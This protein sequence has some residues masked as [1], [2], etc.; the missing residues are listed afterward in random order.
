MRIT[1]DRRRRLL[2]FIWLLVLALATG[3]LLPPQPGT[4]KAEPGTEPPVVQS[5]ASDTLYRFMDLVNDPNNPDWRLDATLPSPMRMDSAIFQL[6]RGAPTD[7]PNGEMIRVKFRVPE[8]GYYE[9]RLKDSMKN[10]AG[11]Y[12]DIRIDGE[13]AASGYSFYAPARVNGTESIVVKRMRLEAGEHTLEFAGVKSVLLDSVGTYY[14][15]LYL[16]S[17]R[18]IPLPAEEGGPATVYPFNDLHTGLNR[19]DWRVEETNPTP[20]TMGTG[21][22]QMIRGAPTADPNGAF[23]RLSFYVPETGP[24]DIRMSSFKNYAGGYADIRI[25]SQPIAEDFSFYAPE[26]VNNVETVLAE[27]LHLSKGPHTLEFAGTQSVLLPSVNSYYLYLYLNRLEL[28]PAWLHNVRLTIDSDSIMESQYVRAGVTAGVDLSNA[29]V[30]YESDNMQVLSPVSP[31][32]LFEAVGQGSATLTATV[33]LDGV[34]ASDSRTFTVGPLHLTS[35]K[36]RSTIYTAQKTANARANALEYDWAK[37]MRD[38]AVAK[39]QPYVDKGWEYLWNSI[40]PQTIPRSY[41]VNQPLGSP[42][43]GRAIDAYGNYPY[44]GDP[45]STP[46]KIVDPSS[47]YVFPTNDFGAYYNSGLDEQGVFRPELADRDLLV[48]EL[49]PER[50]PNWGVDDGYGWVDE[51]GNR[52]TF[53]AYYAHWY[54]WYAGKAIVFN[55]LTALRDAYLYTGDAQ[56]AKAGLV[57]L[58][59]I[60][61]LYPDLDLRQQDRSVFWNSDGHLGTGK[62]VG[63]IWETD[64]SKVLLSAYDAFYPATQDAA[65]MQDVLAFLAAKGQQ[66]KLS[67]K[68]SAVGMRKNIEDGIVRQVYPAVQQANIYGNNGFHQSAL[69]MAAVVLDSLPE[70]RQWL[71]FNFQSGELLRDPIR[72]TGGNI[73]ASL[74]NT[75]DRDGFGN[76]GS[77]TYN[78]GWLQT[79]LVVADLLRGYDLYPEADLYANVKFG[80]MFSSV[81]DLMMLNRY[82]PS[83]GDS[84]YTGN[85]RLTMNKDQLLRAFEVYGDPV[86]AQLVYFLN[87]NRLSAVHGDIFS[88]NPGAIGEDIEQIIDTYGT[89]Q[90]E[91]SHLSGFGFAA[92]RDGISRQSQTGGGIHML[93]P[94]LDVV[95]SSAVYRLFEAS[96]TIQLEAN[97]PNHSITFAFP[98]ETAGTYRVDLRPFRASTYGIYDVYIDNAY[99]KTIDFFGS[100][101]ELEPL[102][103]LALT[104]GEHTLSFRNAGKSPQSSNYKMGVT[105]L[106]L[107]DV[108]NAPEPDDQTALDTLRGLWMYYGTSRIHGHRDTLNLGIHAYG[109]DLAPD[110]GY[111]KFADA[112]DPHR[113]QW[114]NNTISHNTVVVDQA[115]QN[116]QDVAQPLHFDGDGRVMLIDAQ[117]PKVYP[118]TSL[119]RRTTTMIQ[120]DEDH[121][122]AVDFFRVQGGSDHR[123]SFHAMEGTVSAEGLNLVPQQDGSGQYVGSYASP[124]VP[125]GTESGIT[126]GSGYAGSGFHWLKNVDRDAAPPAQFSVDWNVRDTWNMYGNGASAPTDAHLR[127]TMLGELDEAALADGLPPDNKPGNPEQ[128]RYFVGKRSGTNLDSLFTAVI[129]PYK[130]DRY[131]QSISQAEV[132]RNGSIVQTNEA[133]AVKVE[134]AN[135]RT[136]YIVYAPDSDTEYEIDGKLRFRGFFGVYSEQDGVQTYV[137][138]HDGSYFVPIGET[139]VAAVARLTGT[140]ADFTRTLTDDNYIDVQTDLQGIGPSE[141]TGRWIFVDND[142]VRNAAY[143][144]KSAV[145][146]AGGLLRLSIGEKTVVRGYLNNANFNQGYQYDVAVGRAFA[147]PLV[148]ETVAEDTFPITEASVQGGSGSGWH[149]GDATV[150]LH[151]YGNA[152]A[153]QRTEYRVEAERGPDGGPVAPGSGGSSGHAGATGEWRVYNGPV[154]LTAEGEYRFTYRSVYAN[155]TA[156]AEKAF[157]VRIDRTAPAITAAINGVTV[158]DG[159]GLPD[160]TASVV[161]SVYAADTLSGPGRIQVWLD[162]TEHEPGTPIAIGGRSEPLSLRIVAADQAGNARQSLITLHP[163]AIAYTLSG[164][165]Q[166]ALDAATSEAIQGIL[167]AQL[168]YR[169]DIVGLLLE[170]GAVQTAAAYLADFSAYISD[171]SVLQQGLIAPAAS[172]E[173]KSYIA[174]LILGLE[175]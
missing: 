90:P 135:G 64:L 28:H 170:Q 171:P 124:G 60:A 98:V 169:I 149:T 66:F 89:F 3:G 133:R 155:G 95:Q 80:S 23:I 142:G 128:I 126:Q 29:A 48:N 116:V 157:L 41:A 73:L 164:L 107:W 25:D 38:Q 150:E 99:V 148:S 127:L 59:R 151:V 110:L 91:S 139:P 22:Y 125:F 120:V 84:T 19:L 131:I 9:V 147:I 51:Q 16:D 138:V 162:G 94:E 153:V 141:L 156:E 34:S 31:N 12:A 101:K 174:E 27:K 121:S 55:G 137:K 67:F 75:V 145:P 45:L 8:T 54:L 143:E 37:S 168:Q 123:Y 160:D 36:T 63:A 114:M 154:T 152:A 105:E 10:Y 175:S 46:W 5:A 104:E 146:L 50:G 21:V 72:L 87:N 18:L 161:L 78:A 62:A 49:Y 118:Q 35:D 172:L 68:N 122:Y 61:D 56:Y 111:P 77:P 144:I 88:D 166:I 57:M 134:L 85:P 24:Y 158:E 108:D 44:E 173:Q 129:E 159:S 4:A 113:H 167:A 13:L 69:A 32:G 103:E 15:Y 74:V 7:Q 96:A 33:T 70:T 106:R 26:R 11:G 165:E 76:E 97:E 93:F 39:A 43:T 17:F 52:Y 1:S 109:L 53:I 92:L 79:Y 30:I 163:A 42:V 130:G 82:T 117:A 140:V 100:A 40:P 20:M 119:Y 136:D 71:D 6:I 112:V 115:K 83:I 2:P 132:R 47:G 65:V 86:F 81:H 58:D 102:A 14:L